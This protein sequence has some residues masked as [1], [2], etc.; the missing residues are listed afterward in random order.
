MVSM[1]MTDAATRLTILARSHHAGLVEHGDNGEM[2]ISTKE[3]EAITV[4]AAILGMLV[5]ALEAES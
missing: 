4:A 5:E 1:T 3:L 2:L